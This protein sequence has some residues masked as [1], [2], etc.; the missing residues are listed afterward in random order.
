MFIHLTN[1]YWAN[2]DLL[3]V[4]HNCRFWENNGK[5]NKVCAVKEL[6]FCLRFYPKPGSDLC[7]V[8]WTKHKSP[9]HLR[10]STTRPQLLSSSFYLT[11]PL[12]VS[13]NISRVESSLFLTFLTIH[14]SLLT[15]LFPSC[16]I[17]P[18]SICRV[19]NQRSAFKLLLLLML[20]FCKFRSSTEWPQ[21]L[22]F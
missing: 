17:F 7:I 8:Q 16:F 15:C 14:N 6:T 22:Q 9:W 12:D 21:E 1:S 10:P 3:W 20:S 11:T 19:D 18:V 2:I 5:L 4:R 13:Q